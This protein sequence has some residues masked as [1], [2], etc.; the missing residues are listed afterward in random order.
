MTEDG[1]PGFA[2]A[3]SGA[4]GPHFG[5]LRASASFEPYRR[6]ASPLEAGLGDDV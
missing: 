3:V 5:L 2:A 1:E 6:D 4:S